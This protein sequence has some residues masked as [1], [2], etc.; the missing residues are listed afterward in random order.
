MDWIPVAALL[1]FLYTTR[2]GSRHFTWLL[3]GHLYGGA[4]ASRQREM[5]QVSLR[6]VLVGLGLVLR[7]ITSHSRKR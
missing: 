3:C 6:H 1:V 5:S 4:K 2:L 7:E